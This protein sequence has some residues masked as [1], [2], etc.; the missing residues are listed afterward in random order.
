MLLFR[1]VGCC[2]RDGEGGGEVGVVPCRRL[3]L[4]REV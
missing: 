3:L 4:A 2:R 1:L